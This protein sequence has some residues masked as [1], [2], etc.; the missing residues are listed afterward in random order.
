MSLKAFCTLAILLGLYCSIICKI[1]SQRT[2]LFLYHF[3]NPFSFFLYYI[4]LIRMCKKVWKFLLNHTLYFISLELILSCEMPMV[5]LLLLRNIFINST[6]K[7]YLANAIPSP[8]LI[9]NWSRCF[10]FLSIAQNLINL[11]YI[12]VF[13]F[14][15]STYLFIHDHLVYN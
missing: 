9:Q 7:N 10:P 12:V 3:I 8:C 6:M 5:Y 13:K 11:F 2:F 4:I 1:F 15:S 14:V